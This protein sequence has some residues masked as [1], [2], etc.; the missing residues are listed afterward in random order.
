MVQARCSL[1]AARQSGRPGERATGMHSRASSKQH[2][3]SPVHNGRVA[4]QVFDE[5]LARQA[6]PD[7]ALFVDTSG[8]MGTVR[9]SSGG[10]FAV[11]ERTAITGTC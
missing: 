8:K 11:V 5:I 1:R 2:E 9:A 3:G 4:R 7:R 6:H 10:D